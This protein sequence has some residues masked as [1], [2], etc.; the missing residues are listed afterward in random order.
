[1]PFEN[2]TSM[3]VL[4]S[5]PKTTQFTE[6]H[7]RYLSANENYRYLP[8]SRNVAHAVIVTVNGN[9]MKTA[10]QYALPACTHPKTPIVHTLQAIKEIERLGSI[11]YEAVGA[12][13]KKWF[14]R[15][16][17]KIEFKDL[18]G[19]FYSGDIHY[20]SEEEG[21]DEEPE[22][23]NQQKIP[24]FSVD[25]SCHILNI[26]T[27]AKGGE[28]M[29]VDSASVL[30]RDVSPKRT[31][32]Q[33]HVMGASA[34]NLYEIFFSEMEMYLSPE[35]IPIFRRALSAE[36]NSPNEHQYRPEHLH[37]HAHSLIS[38]TE[39][40]QQKN[41]LGAAGKWANTEMM[42][43]ERIAKFIS[44]MFK[45]NIDITIKTLFD[46]LGSSELIDLIHAEV[47]LTFKERFIRLRQ[48]LDPFK[49][50]PVFRKASDLAQAAGICHNILQAHSPIQIKPVV[51][52][53][54]DNELPIPSPWRAVS[55]TI[56]VRM[57]QESKQYVASIIDLE[58]TGLDSTTDNIIE[59]GIISFMFTPTEGILAITDTYTGLQYPGYDISEKITQLTGITN[60]EL[61]TP[62]LKS[63]DWER[64]L[65][66]LEQ[67]DYVICHN[68]QFDRKFLER[69][70]PESIQNKVKTMKF[71]CTQKD[72]NWP[73]RGFN[74]ANLNYL[75]AQLNFFYPAHRA[76]SDCWATLNIIKET[77][78]GLAELFFNIEK[79]ESLLCA[80]GNLY[81]KKE[82]LKE[83]GFRWS[84]GTG[85]FPRSWY[86]FIP[87]EDVSSVKTWLNDE[88]YGISGSSENIPQ[89]HGITAVDRHTERSAQISIGVTQPDRLWSK[90][91]S[92][93]LT[94]SSA[95]TKQKCQKNSEVS[96]SL[97]L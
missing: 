59:I 63:I 27:V 6:E 35:I 49:A 90:R 20:F 75:N 7:F 26:G 93:N 92:D 33:N 91:K 38:I 62:D 29:R 66:Q 47:S 23:D 70:T 5:N 14:S 73:A 37:R 77:E 72:I 25:S 57:S 86:I 46:M 32:T 9:P 60:T 13:G 71:G 43:L 44:L 8:T 83:K 84:D 40:P 89:K 69:Q 80:T 15:R 39:N 4:L 54:W 21:P 11:R 88:V 51:M 28:V 61:K 55:Q 67:S 12:N 64:V 34:K 50:S 24:R 2:K 56:P 17:D 42:I 10:M 68:A 82:A 58:T 45:E 16:A 87:E 36:M 79:T 96:S 81:T 95:S 94:S 74:K 48:E 22:W 53:S 52:G 41:N 85:D 3:S 18:S 30:A 97:F 65:S 19:D 1:M 78:D 76:M 31:V